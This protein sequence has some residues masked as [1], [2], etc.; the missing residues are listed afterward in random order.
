MIIC[1]SQ[2]WGQETP[3]GPKFREESQINFFLVCS[4]YNRRSLS[5]W[6]HPL[7]L[8]LNIYVVYIFI[9]E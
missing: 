6:W 1:N 9:L 2:C 5:N 4:R 3:D 8:A 7:I